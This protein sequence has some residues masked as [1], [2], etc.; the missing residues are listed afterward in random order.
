MV[1]HLAIALVTYNALVRLA[2]V[3]PLAEPALAATSSPAPGGRANHASLAARRVVWAAMAA[4]VGVE[5]A[6]GVVALL[7]VPFGRS[8]ALVP[9][10][11]ESAYLLHAAVGA[12]LGSGSI[13]LVVL[14]RRRPRVDRICAWIGLAGVAL[15]A[16]GGALAVFHAVR[17]LG[18]GLMLL[19]ALIACT[20]YLVPLFEAQTAAGPAAT[21]GPGGGGGYDPGGS[22]G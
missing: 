7:L 20:G 14:A 18:A 10:Q 13:A 6:L 5:L 8:D 11:G 17:L 2:P 19:G 16:A 9:R 3:G 1:M 15:A 21:K 22:Q 12:V 4:L